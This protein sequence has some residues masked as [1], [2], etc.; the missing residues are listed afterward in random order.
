MLQQQ[1]HERPAVT[2]FTAYGQPLSSAP[3]QYT[4]VTQPPRGNSGRQGTGPRGN[5]QRGK[6]KETRT[7]HHCNKPGHLKK[8]C[9]SLKREQAQAQA[10]EGTLRAAAFTAMAIPTATPQRL[11]RR[12]P[13][14]LPWRPHQQPHSHRR[15]ACFVGPSVKCQCQMPRA[16][17][18]P[19]LS[20]RATSVP[21]SLIVGPA[22]T[23]LATSTV[24]QTAVRWP[25]RSTSSSAT[26]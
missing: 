12:P 21:G 23:S 14:R 1:L 18:Q 5:Q 26:A 17:R 15:A 13:R 22:T 3:K 25:A 11:P 6:A 8:D 4:D 7:C 20:H 19:S 2:A 24:S 9:R 16:R 10:Q